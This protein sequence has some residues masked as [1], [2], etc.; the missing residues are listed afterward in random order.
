MQWRKEV[1]S[2]T[3]DNL[4]QIILDYDF[5]QRQGYLP[6]FSFLRSIAKEV[7]EEYEVSFSIMASE[8]Y[9]VASR[10]LIRR[11]YKI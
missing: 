1:E 3:D 9:H 5:L 10:E 6:S 8:I 2:F 7:R 4:L 11:T